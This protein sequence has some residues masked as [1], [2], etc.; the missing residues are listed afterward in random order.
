MPS[1]SAETAPIS[2]I[3]ETLMLQSRSP[4]WCFTKKGLATVAKIRVGVVFGGKSGEHEVSIESA[5][6]VMEALDRTKYDVVPIAI[7]KHGRWHSGDNAVR[8]LDGGWATLAAP[9]SGEA[10]LTGD[11]MANDA[12]G[13]E[14][15][16]AGTGAGAQDTGTTA[17][18]HDGGEQINSSQA[19]Q[20]VGGSSVLP[21]HVAES[22]DVLFPVLHGSYGEDGTVQGMFELLD[23]PYVGAGVAASAVGMDKIL[24]KR[25][26]AAVGLPQVNYV[27]C[28]RT[29]WEKQ[30]DLVISRVEEALSYPCFV[31]PANLGSSVGISKAK[32]R[33]ELSQAIVLAARYDRKVI[34]EEGANVREVEVAVLGNDEPKAS[35]AGEVVPSN[36]FYDYRAK[37]L[38]GESSLLI[39]APVSGEVMD[40]IRRLAVLAYQAV[41]CS[42]LARVDFFVEKGTDRVLVN[43]INTMPGF[44]RFSMY[45][46]LWEATGLSY[47][48]L[49]DALLSLAIDRAEERRKSQIDFEV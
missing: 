7:D 41:D 22:I 13:T 16:E 3:M 2:Y 27:Y 45:P 9:R 8:F 39:P 40:E 33:E 23:I 43:E 6:S 42:G 36:E 15:Q 47:R 17:A 12:A 14:A 10:L 4:H 24:M 37:Y 48:Q 20:P 25:V 28:T 5:K 46:K 26:F 29:E 18:L 11:G 21:G 35:V 49:I 32:S 31:K 19:L 34:I 1:L 38:D 30:P 44:T